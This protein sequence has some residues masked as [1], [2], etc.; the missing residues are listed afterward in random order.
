MPS[1]G[2]RVK[3]V[4]LLG[5][6][7]ESPAA[8]RTISEHRLMWSALTS[9]GD[10]YAGRLS[11]TP[12]PSA[13]WQR[14]AQRDTSV[15]AARGGSPTMAI[16]DEYSTQLH[17]AQLQKATVVGVD[18]T[19]LGKVGA[20]YHDNNTDHPAWVAVRTGLFGTH[21]SLVPLAAAELRGEELHVPFDK[22]QL[23]TA[24]H[25]DPGGELSPQD[26]ID[27]FSHY[28]VPYGDPGPQP[29]AGR[30]RRT[31]EASG[32]RAAADAVTDDAMTRSEEQLQVRTESQPTTRVRL[33]KHIVTEYQQVTVPVRREE[34]RLE[35]EPAADVGSAATAGG[36][37]APVE[38]RPASGAE[39]S[40][41]VRSDEEVRSDDEHVVTLYE[42]RPVVRSETVPVERV[43]LGK[44]AVTEQQTVGGHV[45][46]EEIEVD[47]DPDVHDPR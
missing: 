34:I 3:V 36:G 21:V 11:V 38:T 19:R 26:E 1:I 16:D 18:G 9:G 6:A 41:R 30:A 39:V 47:T 4:L 40:D 12:H 27:L 35:R 8:V 17:Q 7:A 10:V 5:T 37:G 33:R 31:D 23:K 20:V 28:G 13:A 14:C 25:H 2:T 22:Q 29:A 15:A 32:R 44:Q 46:R 42:E 45:R 43:R 24:P